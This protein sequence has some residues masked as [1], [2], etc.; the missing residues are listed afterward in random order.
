M[1]HAVFGKPCTAAIY[2]LSSPIGGTMD[3]FKTY[4]P[5]PKS[6]APGK[7]TVEDAEA[8]AMTAVAFIVGDETLMPRFFALT[9]CGPDDLRTRIGEG[10]FLGAVLDF[11]LGDEPSL[12][13]FAATAG[14]PPEVMMLAREK[15]P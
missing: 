10:A 7:L 4:Q 9:G 13:D 5:K 2:W 11:I 6:F 8:V 3:P 12:L 15:L 1:H 14:L